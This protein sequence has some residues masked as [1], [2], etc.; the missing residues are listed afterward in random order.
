M[1]AFLVFLTFFF[2]LF[3]YETTL[4]SQIKT[5]AVSLFAQ[6]MVDVLQIF[7]N[8]LVM[9]VDDTKIEKKLS[10]I[11]FLRKF[12]SSFRNFSPS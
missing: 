6:V 11:H 8:E 2:R 5:A 4:N 3:V 12:V 1:S 7:Q 10:D 9:S